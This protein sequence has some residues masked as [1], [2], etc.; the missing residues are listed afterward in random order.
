M[1][2]KTSM[3][4]LRYPGIFFIMILSLTMAGKQVHDMT[5]GFSGEAC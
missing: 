3:K 2:M 5:G 4:T 1:E